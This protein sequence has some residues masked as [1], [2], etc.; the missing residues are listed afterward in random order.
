MGGVGLIAFVPI[1]RYGNLGNIER[2][3]QNFYIAFMLCFFGQAGW[4]G[5]DEV[6]LLDDMRANQV[7]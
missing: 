7:A 3:I 2:Y 1:K 5:C 6:G 4:Q